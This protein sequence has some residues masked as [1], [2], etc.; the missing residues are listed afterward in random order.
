MVSSLFSRIGFWQCLR[1]GDGTVRDINQIARGCLLRAEV[2][3]DWVAYVKIYNAPFASGVSDE[4]F[5]TD[6]LNRQRCP[7]QKM[8]EIKLHTIEYQRFISHFGAEGDSIFES[9][10]VYTNIHDFHRPIPT[11]EIVMLPVTA[12]LV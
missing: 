12:V 1:E 3:W 5:G 8:R 9:L 6:G 2:R 7:F 4:P 11:R 10:A